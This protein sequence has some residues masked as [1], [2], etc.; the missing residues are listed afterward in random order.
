MSI[1]ILDCLKR[2][3]DT[4]ICIQNIIPSQN[5]AFMWIPTLRGIRVLWKL[6]QI[7]LIGKWAQNHVRIILY[8]LECFYK[9]WN[10]LNDSYLVSNGRCNKNKIRPM[11]TWPIP[12]P[13]WWLEKTFHLASGK[14]QFKYLCQ[15]FRSERQNK[16]VCYH[17]LAIS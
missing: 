5:T 17:F 16:A 2:E 8:K 9:S 1:G 12:R 11:V 6:S 15:D 7:G 10:S 4:C 13:R 14:S 3:R